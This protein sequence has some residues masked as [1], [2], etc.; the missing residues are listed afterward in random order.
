M[1]ELSFNL[2]EKGEA[3]SASDAKVREG[4]SKT[5]EVVNGNIDNTNLKA[6]AGI[7]DTKLASPSNAVYR[8]IL[9]ANGA[10]SL[11]MSANTFF[12][13][14]WVQ[15]T[16]NMQR[17]QGEG[18]VLTYAFGASAESMLPD[19]TY[20]DAA[21]Y[22]VAGKTTKLRVRAQVNPNATKPAIKFTFGLYPLTITGI[23]DALQGTLGTVISGS[24]VAINEPAASTLVQGN[25]GDFEVPATGTYML[26]V[27]TSGT[28]T[29]NSAV[30][31]SAQLQM[32]HV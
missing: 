20:L 4:L 12:L 29:N 27:V 7:A 11:D 32:R 8:P 23:A 31:C 22:T 18:L 28:L 9:S 10:L 24:T 13:G 3:R 15:T 30:F 14:T 1:T 5:K 21:D 25:S 17:L 19:T 16:G 6:S 26:G 2:P